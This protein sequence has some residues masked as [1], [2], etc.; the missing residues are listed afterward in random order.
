M[1]LGLSRLGSEFYG[2]FLERSLIISS[3]RMFYSLY[4]FYKFIRR[5]LLF[6]KIEGREKSEYE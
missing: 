4:F 1:G 6:K 3:F 5:D 2:F